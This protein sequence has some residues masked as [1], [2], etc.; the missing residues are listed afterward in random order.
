MAFYS[1]YDNLLG[2][3]L[4]AAGGS[5][6]SQVFNGG[7]AV[8]KGLEVQATYDMLANNRTS[9]NLPVSVAYTYTNAFFLSSFKSE[10]EGWGEVERGDE[11]PY[12]AHHQLTLILSLEHR[13]F[14]INISGRYLGEMRTRPGQSDLSTDENIDAYFVLD[15][16]A[17]YNLTRNISLFAN[18]TNFTDEVYMVSTRPAGLRPGR[19]MAFLIGIKAGF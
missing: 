17:N 2:S 8:A 13:N 4:A 10:F 19:P 3:D 18:A 5:G 14:N 15:G 6:T 12:L 9:F 1:D 16:S 7:A 11:L